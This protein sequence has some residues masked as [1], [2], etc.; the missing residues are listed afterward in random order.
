MSKH[1]KGMK[2]RKKI[3]IAIAGATLAIGGTAWAYFGL[4]SGTSS[5]AVGGTKFTVTVGASVGPA[6]TPGGGSDS[7]TFDVVNNQPF[8]Q[9]LTSLTASLTTDSAGGIYDTMMGAFNDSCLASY[10]VLSFSAAGLPKQLAP[11]GGSYST[12]TSGLQPSIS[13]PTNA[14]DESACEGTDPQVTLT[15]S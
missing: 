2:H 5:F 7:M 14:V 15:A 9:T 1:R 4:S 6:L 12:A 3:I 11:N 13:M 8:A 10:F